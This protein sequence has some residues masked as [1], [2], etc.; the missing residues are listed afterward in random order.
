[1]TVH[2]LSGTINYWEYYIWPSSFNSG[3]EGSDQ[4]E[5][6]S[7]EAS[8]LPYLSAK[9]L[10]HQALLAFRALG[11]FLSRVKFMNLFEYYAGVAGLW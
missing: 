4:S 8:K 1:M 7:A 10:V 11:Y 2:C 5:L 6:Q 9:L 3:L